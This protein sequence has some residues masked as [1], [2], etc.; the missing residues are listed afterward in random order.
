MDR[1]TVVTEDGKTLWQEAHDSARMLG[2]AIFSTM[3]VI[4]GIAIAAVVLLLME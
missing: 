1:R 3:C 4:I 2:C